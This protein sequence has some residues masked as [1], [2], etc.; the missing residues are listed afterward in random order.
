MKNFF[1]SENQLLLAKKQKSSFF[2]ET[3]YIL[4]K[5]SL[6]FFVGFFCVFIIILLIAKPETYIPSTKNGILIFVTNVL[7]VLF[8]FF[9][10]SFFISNMGVSE[11][12][13]KI[14]EKPMRKIFNISKYGFY[15][16]LLSFL[17]GYPVGA[18]L[19]N[20][21]YKKNKIDFVDAKKLSTICSTSNPIFILGTVGA[22]ILANKKAGYIILAAHY[23]SA[24]LIGIIF[25]GKSRKEYIKTQ[26]EIHDS[27][28]TDNGLS[29]SINSSVQTILMVGGFICI[30]NLIADVFTNIGFI[31]V[32]SS[33]FS[34][35]TSKEVSETVFTGMFE[36]TRGCLLSQTLN[37]SIILKASL[38]GF[39]VTFGGF[40]ILAQIIVFTKEIG[41]KSSEIIFKKFIQ[42]L[43]CF[44]LVLGFMSI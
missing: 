42:S 35:I 31:D 5:H 16:L 9:F 1:I 7:P 36:M 20:Y 4:K 39:F 37:Q 18:K 3:F 6:K 30:F 38:C 33:L 14:G 23:L 41:I 8:P 25:R 11:N 10:F 22:F 12:L 19:T 26:M 2:K 43:L 32:L 34:N 24:L 44:L 21:F 27:K 28:L 15:I 29:D 13:L 17:C 40:G